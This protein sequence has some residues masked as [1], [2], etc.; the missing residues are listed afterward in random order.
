MATTPVRQALAAG[1][2]TSLVAG[3]AA[4]LVD[5]LWSWRAAGQFVPDVIGKLRLLAYL[6]TAYGLGALVVGTAITAIALFYLRATRVG[7]LIAHA[8]TEHARMRAAAPEKA[9]TGLA[10]A[11]TGIPV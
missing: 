4:G 2:L 10:L 6:A 1:A 7:D 8:R 5:G 11:L 3:A 9:V